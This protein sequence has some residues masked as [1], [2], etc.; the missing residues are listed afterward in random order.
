[1]LAF[2]FTRAQSAHGRGLRQAQGAALA[3]PGKVVALLAF[4]HGIAQHGAQLIEVDALS[5]KTSGKSLRR[6]AVFWE[7]CR[8]KRH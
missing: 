4:V 1:M 8:R 3:P 6:Q 2:F 5:E 7:R